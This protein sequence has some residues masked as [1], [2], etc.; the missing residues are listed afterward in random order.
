M[1]LL[2]EAE[3]KIISFY[4]QKKPFETFKIQL[5][6]LIA[7]PVI[8]SKATI[9]SKIDC[10]IQIWGSNDSITRVQFA[11]MLDFMFELALDKLALLKSKP[12]P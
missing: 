2:Y 1:P 9:H 3:E 8:V 11:E 6:H 12:T 4:I 7:L 5:K 10:L